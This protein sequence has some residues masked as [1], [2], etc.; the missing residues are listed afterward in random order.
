MVEWCGIIAWYHS[1]VEH[2]G[3]IQTTKCSGLLSTRQQQSLPFSFPHRDSLLTREN[4]Q[5]LCM[6][7]RQ[8]SLCVSGQDRRVSVGKS[9]DALPLSHSLLITERAPL[10][11]REQSLR[12]LASQK[13]LCAAGQD[14]S[15]SVGKSKD[16]LSL[17]PTERDSLVTRE[18][19]LCVC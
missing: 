15:V 5:S 14:R 4:K 6:L 18:N 1:V 3:G 2:R 8:K 12:L 19:R 10:D 16:S 9:K 13:S 17:P 7:T 11:T